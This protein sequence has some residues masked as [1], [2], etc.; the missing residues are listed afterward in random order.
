MSEP[1]APPACGGHPRPEF[2]G[3]LLE[4]TDIPDGLLYYRCTDPEQQQAEWVST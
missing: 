3:R 2:A 1:N 4:C